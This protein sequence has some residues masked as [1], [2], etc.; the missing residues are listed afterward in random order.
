MPFLPW[1]VIVKYVMGIMGSSL[2]GSRYLCQTVSQPAFIG[3]R[4]RHSGGGPTIKLS[5]PFAGPATM[6]VLDPRRCPPFPPDP[7]AVLPPLAPQ[8]DGP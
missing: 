1:E 8:P 7:A 6:R 5:P 4:Q 3:Y 2:L